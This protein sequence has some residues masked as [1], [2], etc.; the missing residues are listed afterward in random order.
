MIEI[1]FEGSFDELTVVIVNHDEKTFV[2]T[3]LETAN[4][5]V[6][7]EAEGVNPNLENAE[8]MWVQDL[9]MFLDYL[10]GQG[11]EREDD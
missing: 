8:D 9:G 1:R 11:Y 7:F 3:D 5:L 10:E 6:D 2:V 4:T